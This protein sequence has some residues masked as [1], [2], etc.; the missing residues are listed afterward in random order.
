MW[1][2]W[3]YTHS[4]HH[5]THLAGEIT[6]RKWAGRGRIRIYLDQEST[7]RLMS[8]FFLSLLDNGIS[9]LFGPHDRLLKRLQSIQHTAARGVSGRRKFDYISDV[10]K[11]LHWL[12]IRFRIEFKI[13]TPAFRCVNGD[14]PS[15][16]LELVKP[17]Q[18][19]RNLRSADNSLDLVVPRA[20]KKKYDERF[21]YELPLLFWMT[22]LFPFDHLTPCWVFAQ[23]CRHTYSIKRLIQDSMFLMLRINN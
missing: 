3:C 23:G 21:Y 7:T 18:P 16:L 15:Y 19:T 11:S 1:M 6:R 2:M 9:V 20:R 5:R 17:Y 13:A 8:A 12:P 14:A 22:Y 10:L 4:L